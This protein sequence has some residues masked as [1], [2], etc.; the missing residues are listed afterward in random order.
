[1]TTDAA[2]RL[3]ALMPPEKAAQL[4]DDL[5][6]ERVI[7]CVDLDELYRFEQE[8][9]CALGDCGLDADAV[10]TATDEL[11]RIALTNVA[12]DERRH[13]RHMSPAS[14]ETT[15]REC[16]RIE[17]EHHERLRAEANKTT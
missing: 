12:D 8:L 1:M 14:Y 5:V 9:W 3:A 10:I 16:D 17:R 2:R 13:V 11:I 4:L 15:L 7:A 6:Y